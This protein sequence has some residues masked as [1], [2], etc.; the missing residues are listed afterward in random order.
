MPGSEKDNL[1]EKSGAPQKTK[2]RKRVNSVGVE[3]DG[4]KIEARNEM[5]E[6]NVEHK[7]KKKKKKK[8]KVVKTVKTQ[9]EFRVPTCYIKVL[10]FHKVPLDDFSNLNFRILVYLKETYE[11]VARVFC[12]WFLFDLLCV[13]KIFLLELMEQ[14]ITF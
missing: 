12:C 2:K 10:T 14:L 4:A 9:G 1:K 6:G 8:K 5:E 13:L 3:E 11:N 7:K